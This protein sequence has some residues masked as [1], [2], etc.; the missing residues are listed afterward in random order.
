MK[1]KYYAIS[2]CLLIV[3][4]FIISVINGLSFRHFV[5][6]LFLV[7]LAFLCIALLLFIF[8]DG[9]FS[10]MG[11]SFRRFSYIMAPKRVK[12]TMD[13]DEMYQQKEVTIRQERY[14]VT[15]PLLLI[16]LAG[17]IISLVISMSL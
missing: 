11:H 16:S 2:T 9:A 17:F 10:I 14:P 15:M 1:G 6:A 3:I 5:D 12:E 4:S 13:D 8:S 7:S